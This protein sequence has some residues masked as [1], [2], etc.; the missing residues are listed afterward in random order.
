MIGIKRTIGLLMLL[1]I[2]QSAIADCVSSIKQSA[3]DSRYQLQN[4]NKEV[5]DLKTNLIWQRCAVGQSYSGT[6]CVGGESLHTWA[7]ALQFAANTGS[8]WR[9]PNIK[10]LKTLIEDSCYDMAI[11]QKFFNDGMVKTTYWT[12]SP[13][14]DDS[15]SAWRVNFDD[16]VARPELK[17]E[18]FAIRLVRN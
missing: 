1:N 8:G 4:N 2:Y 6:A 3:P 17:T 9:L 18:L 10:E 14:S 11:N 15:N 7:S 16:G 12:A 5:K 13:N